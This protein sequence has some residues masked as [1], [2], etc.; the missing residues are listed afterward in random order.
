MTNI[1]KIIV[2]HINLSYEGF[3]PS[4]DFFD[5][6]IFYDTDNFIG[7]SLDS[8]S[9]R[10]ELEGCG[11]YKT[12]DLETFKLSTIP[13]D[14][15]NKMF[16]YLGLNLTIDDILDL[17]LDEDLDLDRKFYLESILYYKSNQEGKK[18]QKYNLRVKHF[19]DLSMDFPEDFVSYDIVEN[20]EDFSEFRIKLQTYLTEEE[21][22]NKF[23]DY[24]L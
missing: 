18:L 12:Y 15:K 10:Y 17:M 4:L 21:L 22:N 16:E 20:N 9:L 1:N 3:L 8:K 14:I 5:Y 2:V 13:I 23:K 7:V 24:L 6:H 11:L 19:D